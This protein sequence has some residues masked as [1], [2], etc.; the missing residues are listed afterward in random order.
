ME[1]DRD[2]APTGLEH[3][4]LVI[5]WMFNSAGAKLPEEAP[6]RMLVQRPDDTGEVDEAA[7]SSS[8]IAPPAAAPAV[9]MMKLHLEQQAKIVKEALE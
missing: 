4:E 5:A 6:A 2:C 9:G 3:T 7:E 8:G 1:I